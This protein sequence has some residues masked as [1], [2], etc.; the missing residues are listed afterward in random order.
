MST[1]ATC[2]A[3][4][5]GMV[6]HRRFL[7]C[8]HEFSYRLFMLY[9]DLAELDSLLPESLWW[10]S[11][12]RAIA[13]FDRRDYFGDADLPLDEAVRRKVAQEAGRRPSGPIRMLT[14]GRYFGYCFNPVSFYYCFDEADDH[15]ESIVADI[16]NTPWKIYLFNRQ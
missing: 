4:Y 1:A 15:V 11:S 16:T 13:R 8:T 14:H 3:L 5:E 2:S 6:R 9:L 10:S 7:P 12:R